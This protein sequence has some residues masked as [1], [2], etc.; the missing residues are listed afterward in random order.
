MA[1]IMTAQQCTTAFQLK[2]GVYKLTMLEL[3]SSCEETFNRQLTAMIHKA[4]QFFQ[5]TPVILGFEKVKKEINPRLSLLRFGD[6]LNRFGMVLVAVQGGSEFHKNEAILSGLAW[7]PAK[8]NNTEK[9]I[10]SKKALPIQ[11]CVEKQHK[12]TETYIET[13][14]VEKPVRS[15]QQIYTPGDLVILS[16]VNAG[17][18]LIAGGHIH[19]YGQLRGR[20]L[21]GVNGNGKARVFCSGFEAELISISGQ[22]KL[23]SHTDTSTW[24]THWG[25]SV[26]IA[27][28]KGYLHISNLH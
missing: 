22:Y 19:V 24:T 14:I 25:K 21:A 17:A 10:Q 4:P 6:I 13:R 3:Y 7:L 5:Q 11:S 23:N 12:M 1:P 2:S 18:E 15:G 16:P 27:L 26:L 28:N 8:K 20:A 9:L